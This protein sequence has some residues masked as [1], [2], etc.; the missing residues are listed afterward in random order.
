LQP[1]RRIQP[2]DLLFRRITDD[3]TTAWS[4][5]FAGQ[6]SPPVTSRG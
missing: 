3:E 4:A 5:K 1:G 6:D 2:I